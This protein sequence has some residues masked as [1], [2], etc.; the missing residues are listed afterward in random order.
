MREASNLFY[1]TIFWGLYKPF[2]VDEPR[3]VPYNGTD[4]NTRRLIMDKKVWGKTE[5]VDKVAKKAGM[6]KKDAKAAIEATMG[7][8]KD[9]VKDGAEIRLM[10][11]GT[12][13]KQHREA[14]KGR[15]PQTG[16]EMEIAASDSLSFKSSVRY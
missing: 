14:R 15:N 6:T 5:L 12:F 10:G 7:V 2:P 3:S 4:S 11:F 9:S 1:G 8:I 16:A 13:K